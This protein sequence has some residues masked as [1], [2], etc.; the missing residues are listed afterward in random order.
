MGYHDELIGAWADFNDKKITPL[1][2]KA[3]S[4]NFGI[5]QQKDDAVMMRIRRTGGIIT[6][7]DLVERQRKK[8]PQG[9]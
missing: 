6:L 4:S 8:C 5:Y 1:Q 2:L 9:A 7:A 3:V